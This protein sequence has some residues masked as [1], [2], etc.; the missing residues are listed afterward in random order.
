MVRKFNID[1]NAGGQKVSLDFYV[2]DHNDNSH[3][4][5]IQMKFFSQN[6]LTIPEN[7]VQSLANLHQIAK[8]N[9][10]PFEEMLDYV[11]S[12]LNI[13]DQVL[14][15]FDNGSNIGNKES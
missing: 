15:A 9:A 12:Q 1:C 7:V 11:S 14:K 4:I 6:G 10:I 3:P 8:K 5:N 13:E 2:G